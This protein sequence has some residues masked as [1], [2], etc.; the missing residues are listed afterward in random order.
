M[1]S[2]AICSPRT[3][4]WSQQR[5]LGGII[6]ALLPTHAGM[7]RVQ[8]AVGHSDPLLPTHAGMVPSRDSPRAARPAAP[9]ARGDG[10][11]PCDGVKLPRS[12]SPRTRGWSRD[13]G[14]RPGPAQLLPTHAGMVPSRSQARRGTTAAP[15]A[16]G[17]GPNLADAVV[18]MAACSPRTRGWS[19]RP[20]TH[21][22]HSPLLPTHAGMVPAGCRSGRTARTAP[23]ARG[24]GP[25]RTKERYPMPICSPRTRGWSQGPLGYCTGV[26]LLPTHAGMVPPGCWYTRA[27]Q[28]APHARGDG[29]IASSVPVRLAACSPR[30][31]GWSRSLREMRRTSQL[32]PTHAGMVPR[33]R[34]RQHHG[35][36]APHAR[37]D[38]PAYSSLPPWLQHCSPRTRG[39]SRPCVRSRRGSALLPTH[40]GMV[41]C[42]EPN[43]HRTGPA[44]H[45]RGDGPWSTTSTTAPIGCSPRT[46]GWSLG[47]HLHRRVR[48]LL[49]TH[50]GTVPQSQGICGEKE[51]APHARGDGPNSSNPSPGPPRCSPRT[52]GWSRQPRGSQSVCP[53]RH[54]PGGLPADPLMGCRDGSSESEAMVHRAW[55]VGSFPAEKAFGSTR[56]QRNSCPRWR[57]VDCR[58]ESCTRG[59]RTESP[60]QVAPSAGLTRT[61][62]PLAR[63]AP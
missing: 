34:G 37:G 51:S 38:G 12:C 30:T 3:R 55:I 26:G 35:S 31:R 21:R 41:P 60:A 32:L 43:P 7:V 14:E 19:H 29:P 62:G 6:D 8:D 11:N 53:E 46:R 39:W 63:T 9:H 50:A 22:P 58:R 57:A 28:A 24:D 13:A 25:H 20:R 54:R 42:G 23:H 27:P 59:D 49:P 45:A 1:T 17:D 56:R 4:G 47:A 40:A 15:H 16:R 44:P 5:Q 10:P 52:R 2:L 48:L 61:R 18:L 36:P 33:A